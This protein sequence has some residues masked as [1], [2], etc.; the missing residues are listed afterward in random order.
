MWTS[1]HPTRERCGGH[2]DAE[3]IA[4]LKQLDA[5]TRTVRFSQEAPTQAICAERMIVPAVCLPACEERRNRPCV[6]TWTPQR[7]RQSGFV[8]RRPRGGAGR[9]PLSKTGRS[10]GREAGAGAAE[11]LSRP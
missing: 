2:P 6:G 5:S 7:P 4:R 1:I 11:S 10:R 3:V 9:P 8:V